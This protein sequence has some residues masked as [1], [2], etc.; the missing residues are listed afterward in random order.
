MHPDYYSP[1]ADRIPDAPPLIAPVTGPGPRPLWSV[2]IPTYNCLAYLR[3]ALESVL[4]Q[5]PGPEHMQIEVVDDASTDGDVAGLVRAVGRGR[6][7]YFQQPANR[8]S[9]RNFETCLNRAR[10][11]WVHLLHGDDRVTPGFYAEIEM[12]LRRHPEAGAAFTNVIHMKGEYAEPFA[13]EP[14]L[15]GPGILP[16]F[17]LR[18]AQGQ[19][20]QPPAMVVKRRVYEQL[21]G[22][23]AVHYG[24]DW[25][26]W[27]RIAAH[28]PVAYSPRCL[29]HYRYLNGASL[30]LRSL[31]TGQNIRDV[32]TVIDIM[33]DYLPAAD[34]VRI[35]RVARRHY[36]DYCVALA[37]S[38]YETDP[39][40]AF[41]Q[42][43]GALGMSAGA[44]VLYMV[45][46]LY[47]KDFVRYKELKK[48]WRGTALS[49][50]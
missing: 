29:A 34:R 26:M 48:L 33:Q 45:L 36:A 50:A 46:K 15:S 24:E 16:N 37:H 28:C 11:E 12:L 2:M 32:T 8:G 44:G 13:S 31:T 19:I 6:V 14:L 10:G 17:L 43:H 3:E 49:R 42:A 21:G 40:T 30:T 35:R 25:E 7:G 38:L 9:L 22:F 4:E 20:I 5:D 23:F 47:V 18:L 27:T 39:P 41:V 1:S